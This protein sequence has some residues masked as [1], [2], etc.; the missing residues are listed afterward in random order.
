MATPNAQDLYDLGRAQMLVLRPDLQMRPGD[1][2]DASVWSAAAMGDVILGYGAG[3]D[4]ARFLDGAEDQ[5]L[6]QLA[7]DRWSVTRDA[8]QK[9]LGTVTFT[10]AS[11]QSG[12]IPAGTRVATAPD[13]AGDFQE[14]VT[15]V[16]LVFAIESSKSVTATAVKAGRGGNVQATRITRILDTLF[17]AGFTVNN[18]ARFVGGSDEQDDIDYRE[19]VRGIN[20]TRQRAIKAALE[21]GAKT[22]PGVFTATAVIDP[23]TYLVTVYVA[24]ADGNSNS[25]MVAAVDLALDDWAAAGATVTVV[26]GNLRNESITV[27][28]AVRAGVDT[29]ALRERVREAIVGQVNR[30]KIGDT[31]YKSYIAAAARAADP[32]GIVDVEVNIPALSIVPA[33]NEIIRTATTLVTVN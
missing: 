27:T 26:G 14:F 16:N 28:L 11:P 22:V 1:I 2:S 17:V 15:D 3:R 20:R 6:D 24:D 30:L 29:V 9:A 33:S 18:A 7:N 25:A 5:D 10:H 31:L 32:I 21:A 13:A 19:E 12:T 4:K 8:A 23:V